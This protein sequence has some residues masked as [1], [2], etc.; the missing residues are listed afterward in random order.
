MAYLDRSI[1]KSS[2]EK[3]AIGTRLP[4]LYLPHAPEVV[5]VG[6]PGDSA[7]RIAQRSLGARSSAVFSTV[8]LGGIALGGLWLIWL[9]IPKRIATPTNW[10]IAKVVESDRVTNEDDPNKNS[11]RAG[12]EERLNAKIQYDIM[13]L[14]DEE[15]PVDCPDAHERFHGKKLMFHVSID[16][17]SK[18]FKGRMTVKPNPTRVSVEI[19][20]NIIAGK[21]DF[22]TFH[23][24][25]EALAAIRETP[26]SKPVLTLERPLAL[27]CSH[28]RKLG[29]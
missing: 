12:E 25:R 19:A 21:Q 3:I 26:A 23:F 9:S 18:P 24:S 29:F 4:L 13:K 5:A 17:A 14:N 8:I 2:D 6:N 11:Q 22:C 28:L 7:E 20:G 15:I 1:V 27:S 16:G 10:L